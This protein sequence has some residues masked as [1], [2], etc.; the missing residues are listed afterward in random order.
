M[1]KCEKDIVN[2]PKIYAI[3]Y[4]ENTGVLGDNWYGGAPCLGKR[5]SLTLDQSD[6]MLSKVKC[7][8]DKEKYETVH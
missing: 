6:D 8:L 5:L 1:A 4:K 7:A 2:T 3:G